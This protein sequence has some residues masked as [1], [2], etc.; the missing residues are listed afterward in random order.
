[1]DDQASA[2]QYPYFRRVRDARAI[3]LSSK[4]CLSLKAGVFRAFMKCS[5][6]RKS[7]SK[8]ISQGCRTRVTATNAMPGTPAVQSDSCT[9]TRS[10]VIPCAFQCVKAQASV[11]GYCSRTTFSSMVDDTAWRRIGTQFAFSGSSGKK[12]R[13]CPSGEMKLTESN[14]IKTHRG[15]RSSIF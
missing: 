14:S 10:N 8:T 9:R 15:V 2:S 11:K 1:V 6:A 7:C 12:E 5:E 3:C 4:R 13:R